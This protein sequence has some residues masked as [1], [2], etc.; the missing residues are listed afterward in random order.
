MI[1]VNDKIYRIRSYRNNLHV[2]AYTVS[3]LSPSRR[4]ISGVPEGVFQGIKSE[5]IHQ[6]NQMD[7]DD[8]LILSDEE[9]LF[10]NLNFFL[11]KYEKV[12]GNRIKV[13]NF[14]FEL[15]GV[16]V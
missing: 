13:I 15:D 14:E 3:H 11:R 9:H 16:L 2:E 10:R 7:P 4:L 6:F 5:R 8:F 12:T 1:N